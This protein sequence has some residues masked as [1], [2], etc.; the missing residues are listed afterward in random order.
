MA[1][2]SIIILLL[3]L[4]ILLLNFKMCT[5]VNYEKK[6]I[7]YAIELLKKRLGLSYP[8]DIRNRSETTNIVVGGY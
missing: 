1:Y 2:K 7:N 3:S 8:M 5:M 6:M 4:I